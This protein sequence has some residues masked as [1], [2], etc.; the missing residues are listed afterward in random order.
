MTNYEFYFGTPEKV[1]NSLPPEECQMV[2]IGYECSPIGCPI[3][4]GCNPDNAQ[5][6]I[7]NWLES[8]REASD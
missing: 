5:E 2:M 1:M 4:D 6:L 8:E 3:Y 7:L